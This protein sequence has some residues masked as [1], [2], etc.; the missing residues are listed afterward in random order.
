MY[1]RMLEKDLGGEVQGGVFISVVK[2]KLNAVLG[3]GWGYGRSKGLS[4]G[5]FQLTLD[6]LDAF[7]AVYKNSIDSLDFSSD[8]TSFYTCTKCK[9]KE[10]CRTT[11]TLNGVKG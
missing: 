6:K 2:N 7:I 8:K 9:Y 1:V 3:S 4:R 11:Y 5:D 10:I